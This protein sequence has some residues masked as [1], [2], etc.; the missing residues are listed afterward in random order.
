MGMSPTTLVG[1][2]NSL[3]AS[4]GWLIK[5]MYCNGLAYNFNTSYSNNFILRNIWEFYENIRDYS[6]NI[7]Q[8]SL[9]LEHVKQASPVFRVRPSPMLTTCGAGFNSRNVSRL[10]IINRPSKGR[11]LPGHISFWVPKWRSLQGKN[12][13]HP[14]NIAKNS[15]GKVTFIRLTLFHSI[16]R[17]KVKT[18][19]VFT[20]KSRGATVHVPEL[21]LIDLIET[22]YIWAIADSIEEGPP[23]Q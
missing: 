11:F 20:S 5:I 21:C 4:A 19:D 23:K 2:K 16:N 17:L 12:Q 18:I 6:S 10:E 3:V 22:N 8:C 9:P 13:H 1:S 14:V 7:L 15:W